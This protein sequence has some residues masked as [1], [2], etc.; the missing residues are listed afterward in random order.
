MMISTVTSRQR[1]PA[2]LWPYLLAI[3]ST[4]AVAAVHAMFDAPNGNLG[5]F[6]PF[7]G[8]VLISA[9]FGGIESGLIATVLGT[10]CGVFLFPASGQADG[11][12]T[13]SRDDILF[14][15]AFVVIGV[16]LSSTV[17]ALRLGRARLLDGSRRL[18]EEM[19]ERRRAE[20]DA[21]QQRFW[22]GRTLDSIGDAVMIV[23]RDRRIVM[24]NAVAEALTGYRLREVNGRV[25]DSV[26]R[27]ASQGEP[28]QPPERYLHVAGR[29]LVSRDGIE[30]PIELSVAPLASGNESERE[31]QRSIVVF[32]D[33]S[34]R[35]RAEARLRASE[36]RL[37]DFF[38]NVDVGLILTAEDGTILSAN[39][40][41]LELLDCARAAYVGRRLAEFWRDGAALEQALAALRE[42]RSIRHLEGEMRAADGSWCV[43]E[44]DANGHWENEV[45]VYA[46]CVIR[47]IRDRKRADEARAQL[48]ENLQTADR[49]KDEFLAVLAHELRNPLAPLN[50]CLEILARKPDDATAARTRAIMSRQTAQMARLVDDLLQISRITHN[51]LE[52][53]REHVALATVIDSALEASRV[54]IDARGHALTTRIAPEP[55]FVD[56]DPARLAQVFSNLLNN[57]AKFT[58]MGGR[59]LLSVE[60]DGEQACIT[61][62]DNGVGI[63]PEMLDKVFDTFT[64]VEPSDEV[65]A[66]GLGLGLSLV[67]KITEMHGGRVEA[68]SPGEGRGA[69]FVVRLPLADAPSA[70]AARAVSAHQAKRP[71]R[72]LIVDDNVDA[73]EALETTFLLDGHIT[74]RAADGPAGLT[75]IEAF[76]PELVF[77]DIGLPKMDGYEVARRARRTA[78]G[79]AATLVALT[80][81]GQER[82]V[83]RAREAGFD[84]HLTKPARLDMLLDII[85]SVAAGQPATPSS[86]PTAET[87]VISDS[88]PAPASE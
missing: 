43:V 14:V 88:M 7:V 55:L 1:I 11:D 37:A 22:F 85:A 67:Q 80:G 6:I 29:T 45:F 24:M 56:A 79:Q 73:A 26:L 27:L 52:L 17:A 4:G 31:S 69:S 71:V 82:D 32:R 41:M 84:R 8:S 38:E 60:R 35:R 20:A 87:D 66:G 53:R 61:V 72:I 16:L 12:L 59:I 28:A 81:F 42:G 50:A 10:L 40:S 65:V 68:R 47:D 33:V 44:M 15:T 57:A 21:Q 3:G 48:M 23:D 18:A 51:R 83:Q 36:Q 5:A 63:A 77:L 64:R 76:R 74:A 70:P 49:K 13:H 62:Q 19:D 75:Q 25:L 34:E 78:A 30:R 39:H 46:R 54:L 9:W 86:T 2:I 58:P